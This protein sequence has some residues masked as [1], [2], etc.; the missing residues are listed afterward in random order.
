MCINKYCIATVRIK[1]NNIFIHAFCAS[2]IF[3]MPESL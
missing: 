2:K 3:K 1:Y